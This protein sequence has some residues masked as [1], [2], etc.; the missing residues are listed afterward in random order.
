[1][2]SGG[3]GS[4]NDI[5]CEGGSAEPGE[6][7]RAAVSPRAPA[8]PPPPPAHRGAALGGRQGGAGGLVLARPAWMCLLQP[9]EDVSAVSAGR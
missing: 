7:V 3:G 2:T 8:R 1:M 9:D 6:G 4:G 5:T